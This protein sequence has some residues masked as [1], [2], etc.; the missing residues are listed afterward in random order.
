NERCY[1]AYYTIC[2][3]NW[4]ELLLQWPE[5][6]ED[7]KAE[8]KRTAATFVNLAPSSH[9]AH[10]CH[11]IS[12]M[13]TGQFEAGVQDLRHS[14]ELNPNDSSVL[15]LLAHSEVQ[16]NNLAE[17]K[18]VAARAIRINPKDWMTGTAYL[19]LAQAA[20]VEGDDRF[21][22]WA[23]KA[24]QAEPKA[25]MRRILMIA[26]AAEIEDRNL[27][28]EHLAQLNSFAPKFVSRFLNDEIVMFTV[29]E[30]REKVVRALRKTGFPK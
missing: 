6:P 2:M 12:K 28:E 24:I 9:V 22:H 15:S 13:M 18:T 21:R 3:A 20:F 17:S 23:E 5:D 26:Y 19:A 16:L 14:V 1:R 7:T 4:I 27:F 29:P 8:L 25:P 11:G 30:H 10:Y